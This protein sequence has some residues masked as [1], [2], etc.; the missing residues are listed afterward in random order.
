VDLERILRKGCPNLLAF[1]LLA[2]VY[3][4]VEASERIAL[5][6]GNA[7]YSTLPRLGNPIND[8]NA[9]AAK[10]TT[11]GFTLV[12]GRAHLNVN[13]AEMKRLI[14]QLGQQAKSG[15]DALFY[16]AGHGV[17]GADDNY[18]IP[19]DDVD[20]RT[21]DDVPD[22]AVS[23]R[24]VLAR[25]EE[26]G[27]GVNI[28]ILDACRNNPLP[29]KRS[30]DRGLARMSVPTGSFIAYAASPGQ[31]ADDGIGTA[32]GLFT[33]SLLEFM[34]QQ[35]LRI[36]DL[37][38][39]VLDQVSSRN[40]GQEPMWEAK[41]RRPFYF[42]SLPIA[43]GGVKPVSDPRLSDIEYWSG[44]GCS[45]GNLAGCRAYAGKYPHGQFIE[46][47]T[48]QLGR[49]AP[50]VPSSAVG[51][52]PAA[53]AH[54]KTPPRVD[55]QSPLKIGMEWYPDASRRINEEGRCVVRVTVNADGSISLPSLSSSSG[56]PRLDE[57]CINAVQGQRML[58]AMEDGR[59]VAATV[60]LPIVWKLYHKTPE[61]P[62]RPTDNN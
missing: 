28:I 40:P 59:P 24:S 21:R 25:L 19:V 51:A 33:A 2:C 53:V 43:D 47:A 39:K 56:F 44:S 13:G 3:L 35:G 15:D 11:I 57:A 49:P 12:G 6:I 22:F 8:A 18:L 30:A 31:T 17:G 55:P 60:E 62:P 4:P 20:I 42:V 26:R 38:S 54:S 32:N 23:A 41:L 5:V 36:D 9:V 1:L 7:Q 58:P 50:V 48:L 10:L 14:R 46:L 37:M 27:P 29:G 45:T 16:F 34:G 61:P 52:R